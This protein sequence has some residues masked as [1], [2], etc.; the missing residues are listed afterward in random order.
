MRRKI[1]SGVVLALILAGVLTVRFDIVLRARAQEERRDELYVPDYDPE[2]F[3]VQGQ[4]YKL[5]R[6][7]SFKQ[8]GIIISAD[9]IVLDLN[10]HKI[11][12]VY[13]GGKGVVAKS[14][15]GVVVRNGAV[16]TFGKGIHIENSSDIIISNVTSKLNVQGIRIEESWDIII[17]NVMKI[18][19]REEGVSIGKSNNVT[20]YDGVIDSTNGVGVNIFNSTNITISGNNVT[21][22]KSVG[23]RAIE[24]SSNITIYNNRMEKNGVGIEI[25]STKCVRISGNEIKDNSQSAIEI[26]NSKNFGVIDRNNVTHSSDGYCVH[27]KRSTYVNVWDNNILLSKGLGIEIL[28]SSYL[29]ISRN[30]VMG[31]SDGSSNGIRIWETSSYITVTRNEIK[32]NSE[33]GIRIAGGSDN[34]TISHNNISDTKAGA[35][36]EISGS[37]GT[38]GKNIVDH[39]NIT[40]NM[41]GIYLDD[42]T[43]I[44]VLN[45]SATSNNNAGI[46]LCDSSHNSV[47]GNRASN[48][49]SGILI[50]T[51]TNNYINSNTAFNNTS[52]I[53]LEKSN[54]N[55]VIDNDVSENKEGI[56]LKASSENNVSSNTATYN[57]DGICI[58]GN[59]EKNIIS[60][61][62][63]TSNKRNGIV[64]QSAN[65]SIIFGNNVT[66]NNGIGIEVSDT[67]FYGIYKNE[68]LLNIAGIVLSNCWNNII[69]G[70]TLVSNMHGVN[71]TQNSS[72]N[73]VTRNHVCLNTEGGIC[74]SQGTSNNRIYANYV[75]FNSGIAG[76]W[77]DEMATNNSIV[78]NSV[79]GNDV[80]MRLSGSNNIIYHNN[81][82]NSKKQQAICTNAPNKWYT[83]EEGN[84]WN[85]YTDVD[86]DLRHPGVWDH[87]YNVADVGCEDSYPLAGSLME[88]TVTWGR[89]TFYITTI[90]NSTVVGL[91]FSQPNKMISFNVTGSSGTIGFCKVAIPGEL[92]WRF[93]PENILI[94]SSKTD[95]IIT[96]SYI[97]FTFTHEQTTHNITIIGTEVI[98]AHANPDVNNDGIVDII[99]LSSV[100][101]AFN[102][103]LITDPNDFRYWIGGLWH[104]PPCTACVRWPPHR[105]CA[106]LDCNCVVNIVD[107]SIVAEAFGRETQEEETN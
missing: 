98:S 47:S 14:R 82:M 1:F 77:L 103:E 53:V 73:D 90:S 57:E 48:N 28:D 92:L 36:I 100:A 66:S 3:D 20:V 30:H 99:D 70:N 51:A 42:S 23:V 67:G 76:I 38:T 50:Y 60:D 63:V 64:I 18:E 86:L 7:V 10:G 19:N 84:Y 79:S 81:F 83:D 72:H 54:N 40:S 35:G 59:S 75:A 69:S 21:D 44:D 102:S 94:D 2:F 74:L 88:F 27:V 15:S 93:S 85:D 43:R 95:L 13:M 11:S 9:N 55:G 62:S 25:L 71:I 41:K 39:N 106:D 33:F 29:N 97:Y 37:G 26:D 101:T 4:V 8:D 87:P 34:I 56:L 107:I 65:D 32:S 58:T 91:C 68:V 105:T 45:N 16:T 12:N 24:F 6:D 49:T 31:A 61:N 80:G 22:N 96:P 17:S 52:G 5:K 78:W 104:T 46:K 89:E